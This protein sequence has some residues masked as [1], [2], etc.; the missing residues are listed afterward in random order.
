[1]KQKEKTLSNSLTFWLKHEKFFSL[2]DLVWKEDTMGKPMYRLVKK[3]K[4]VKMALKKLNIKEYWN[5]SEIVR[6]VRESLNN[7]QNGLDKH[8]Q[9]N[10]LIKEENICSREL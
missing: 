5:I 4:K 8:L 6:C 2:V 9:D 3:L 1:M 10:K 7:V